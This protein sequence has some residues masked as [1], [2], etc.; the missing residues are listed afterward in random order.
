MPNFPGWA[1]EPSQVTH[2]VTHR[3]RRAKY[4]RGFEYMNVKAGRGKRWLGLLMPQ[5]KTLLVLRGVL[6]RIE[7]AG[8]GLEGEKGFKWPHSPNWH[9]EGKADQENGAEPSRK[10]VLTTHG[11]GLIAPATVKATETIP[12]VIVPPTKFPEDARNKA[13]K[14]KTPIGF[15]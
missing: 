4:L 1:E 2:Q 8:Q 7:L 14:Q 10:L 12:V 5:F 3:Q 9:L 15:A 13:K 11:L 6:D